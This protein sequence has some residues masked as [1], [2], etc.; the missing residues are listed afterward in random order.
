MEEADQLCERLA[1]IDQ[2][3]I[4][5]EGSPADLKRQIGDDVVRVSLGESAGQDIYEKASALVAEQTYVSG[6]SLDEEGLVVNVRDG[7]TSGPALL[8]LLIENNI[9]I[10]KLG[11]S[12][13]TLDDVFLTYTGR[14]IRHDEG[15]GDEF[16][17]SLRPW[18]GLR[19]R[20]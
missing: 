19:G 8:K 20:R 2:G 12:R 7:E 15:G 10:A 3:Q 5:A 4:V 16:A 6:N 17:Q 14:T 1:I 13:P 9:E 11:I 18:I